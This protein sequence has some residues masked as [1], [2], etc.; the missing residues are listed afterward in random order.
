MSGGNIGDLM[1]AAGVT[2]GWFAGGFRP[3]SWEPNGDAVCAGSQANAAG[4]IVA[5]YFP[6]HEPF[7]YF[8]STANRHHVPPSSV[9]AIGTTDA[10]NHQYDLRDFDAALAAG[11]LPQVSFLKA[12]SAEDAH[13]GYSGPLDEQKFV[14]RVL[15]ELQQ[16]PEWDSTAVFLAYDDSDGWYDHVHITPQQSSDGPSDA[17]DGV[18]ICGPQPPAPGSYRGRCGPGPRLPL[19]LVSPYAKQNFLDSTQTEQA[20]I[21]RFIEDNWNLGRIGDQSFDARAASLNNMF[22]FTP[23]SPPAPKLFL[24]S[25]TGQPLVGVPSHVAIAPSRPDPG[26]RPTPT[27]TPTATASPT[28]T[29]VPP[30][31][32]VTPTPK[33]AVK[34]SCRTSGGGKRVTVSC[35]ASGK[36][37]TKKTSVRFQLMSKKKTLATATGKLAKKKVKVI[38]RP[39]KAL[40]KG[41]YTLRITLTQQGKAKLALT[42]TVRLK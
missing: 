42:R 1:N 2:W 12:V 29:A 40:K 13:P 26:P 5:D 19:L 20:S 33:P 22:D 11:N 16:S 25:A 32:T 8:A 24:D 31:P 27:A 21:T 38:I 35:T 37:A 36:D 6:H 39:K 30:K 28:A 7:Q 18:G 17:L 4:G 14:A 34:L 3:T 41:K 15:N 23:G 9:A 10:A